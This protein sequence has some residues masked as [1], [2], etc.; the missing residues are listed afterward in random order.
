[1]TILETECLSCAIADL[2][3]N[4]GNREMASSLADS[5]AAVC[6]VVKLRLQKCEAMT[7]PCGRQQGLQLAETAPST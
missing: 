6:H 5:Y 2:L 1:M 7:N 3:Q 4:I